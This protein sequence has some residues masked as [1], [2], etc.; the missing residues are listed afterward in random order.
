MLVEP[1]GKDVS[2]LICEAREPQIPQISQIIFVAASRTENA[3]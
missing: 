1:H 3:A 2:A